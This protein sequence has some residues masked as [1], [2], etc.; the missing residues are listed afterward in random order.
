MRT[1]IAVLIVASFTAV[2]AQAKADI[3]TTYNVNGTFADG[4]TL[5][6]TVTIDTTTAVATSMNLQIPSPVLGNLNL[7][8]TPSSYVFAT[9]DISS[10]YDVIKILLEPT[11]GV[12]N[13]GQLEVAAPGFVWPSGPIPLINSSNEDVAGDVTAY[14][15]FSFQFGVGNLYV[16]PLTSGE[17]TPINTPEPATLTMLASGFVAFGGFELNRRRRRGRATELSPAN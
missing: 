1:P 11:S 6:G 7:D 9:S 16:S 15:R 2:T 3:V 14:G 13:F 12:S 8:S 17:L 4:A 5:S 10:S